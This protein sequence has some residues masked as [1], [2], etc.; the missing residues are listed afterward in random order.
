MKDE[1]LWRKREIRATNQE[2]EKTL[3]NTRKQFKLSLR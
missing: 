1:F 2:M 3:K